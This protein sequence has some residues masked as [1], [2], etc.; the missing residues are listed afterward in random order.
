MLSNIDIENE[1]GRGINI[2]PLKKENIKENSINLTISK[3]AWSLGQGCIKHTGKGEFVWGTLEHKD[4][5]Q[6]KGKKCCYYT[7]EN[8]N[9]AEYV[10]LL[11][12]VTTIIETEEV[13]AVENYIGGALHSKV[14]MVAQGIGDFGTMLG[15]GFCGHMMISLHNITDSIIALPIGSTFASLTFDYLSTPIIQRTSATI[16]GHVD[17]FAELGIDCDEKTRSELTED[18]KS[19]IDGVRS[20][21]KDS[22][23]YQKFETKRKEKKKDWVKKYFSKERLITYA[24]MGAVFVGVGVLALLADKATGKEIWVERFFNVGCSGVVVTII[25]A[26][27][28]SRTK[29]Y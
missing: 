4:Y 22:N 24:M 8:G 10:L 5:F 17:K 11:P 14:G 16:S 12:H 13:I 25:I 29:R 7:H 21:M 26:I 28:N 19:N 15:P 1:L 2:F 20:Q 6:E 3:Y 27:Y 18:W 23:A 9:K